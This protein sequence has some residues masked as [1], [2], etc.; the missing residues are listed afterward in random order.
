MCML[1]NLLL[2]DRNLNNSII[3][4]SKKKIILNRNI[5]VTDIIKPSIDFHI[6]KKII[7]YITEKGPFDDRELV[8][9]LIWYNSSG[10]NYRKPAILYEKEKYSAILPFMKEF[11]KLYKIW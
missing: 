10:I 11:Y 8:Q 6:T 4:I 5:S 3:E 9:K 1:K 7:D 2:D